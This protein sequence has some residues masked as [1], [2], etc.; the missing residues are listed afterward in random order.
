MRFAPCLLRSLMGQFLMGK[1]RGG[2]AVNG[3]RL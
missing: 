2:R 1:W 3:S